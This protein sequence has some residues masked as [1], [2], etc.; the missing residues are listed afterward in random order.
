M[1]DDCSSVLSASLS[2]T[3]CMVADAKMSSIRVEWGSGSDVR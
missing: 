3:S 2:L 1:M